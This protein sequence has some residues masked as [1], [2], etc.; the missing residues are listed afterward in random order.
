MNNTVEITEVLQGSPFEHLA[1]EL[2]NIL[3]ETAANLDRPS[4]FASS[5][6]YQIPAWVF[7]DGD[8]T[9]RAKNPVVIRLARVEDVF[10]AEH[11]SLDIYAA[12]ATAEQ[13]VEDFARHVVDCYR[14]YTSQPNEKL[15]G[16]AVKLKRLFQQFSEE[17]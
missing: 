14:F 11:D 8:V 15:I 7:T 12:G 4:V 13:A 5:S 16:Q 10:L 6:K 1:G 2:S 17:D 9:L 3:V